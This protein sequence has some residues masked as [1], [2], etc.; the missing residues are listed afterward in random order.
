MD[1]LE[2]I[3]NSKSKWNL[4][5]KIK[6]YEWLQVWLQDMYN[7]YKNKDIWPLIRE[8]LNKTRVKTLLLKKSK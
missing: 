4:N 8:V 6:I 3:V 2:Q 1:K 5:I 7:Q